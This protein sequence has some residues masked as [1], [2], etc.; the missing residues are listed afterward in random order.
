VLVILSLARFHL[1]MSTFSWKWDNMFHLISY[2]L[3]LLLEWIMVSEADI[4]F[5]MPE[6]VEM[7]TTI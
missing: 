1:Y 3:Q 7:R 5:T 2:I 4:S 6:V